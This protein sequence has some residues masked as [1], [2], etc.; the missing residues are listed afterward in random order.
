M[1]YLDDDAIKNIG[2]KSVGNN[3][4]IS[5]SAVF[6]NAERI[7]IGNNVRIDDFCTI[8][9]CQDG[10]VIIGNYVHIA[11][12]CYIEAPAGIEFCDFSGLAARC[13]VYGGSDDYGG[14]YLTN[15]C[16]P[17]KY[18]SCRASKI[19][20]GK[21]VVVGTCSVILPGAILGDGSAIGAMSMVKGVIPEYKIAVGT[22]AKVVKSRSQKLIELESKLNNNNPLG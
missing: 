7:E 11:S 4:R 18:R 13:T 8:S 17:L 14:D 10:F 5:S 21:H 20:L 15:P 1:A 22:P 12:Y 2:F 3:V 6:Y 9:A 16:V 19:V